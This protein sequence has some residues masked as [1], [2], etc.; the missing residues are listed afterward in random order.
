ML[1]MRK[2]RLRHTHQEAKSHRCNETY[3]RA[4]VDLPHCSATTQHTERSGS[5]RDERSGKLRQQHL[6]YRTGTELQGQKGLCCSS[7]F[8]L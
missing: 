7:A 4:Q 8:C 1:Q 6:I 2:V 3:L 5:K